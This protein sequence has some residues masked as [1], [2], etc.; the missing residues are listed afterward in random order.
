[1][2]NQNRK[3]IKAL[4]IVAG[5]P[6]KEADGRMGSLLQCMQPPMKVSAPCSASGNHLS[7]TSTVLNT[8]EEKSFLQVPSRYLRDTDLVYLCGSSEGDVFPNVRRATLEG[9][10][11]NA[12]LFTFSIGPGPVHQPV[13]DQECVVMVQGTNPMGDITCFVTAFTAWCLFPNSVACDW[14]DIKTCLGGNEKT[15][16]VYRSHS[17][18]YEKGFTELLGQQRKGLQKSDGILLLAAFRCVESISWDELTR[19]LDIL[20][21]RVGMDTMTI[22]LESCYSEQPD[23]IGTAVLF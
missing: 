15:L 12:F 9:M 20:Q 6:A 21:S 3:N 8:I 23:F 14:A 22:Y 17:H 7:G 19:P 4:F 18:D 10:G 2:V 11:K 16:A 1:M 13:S 5:K